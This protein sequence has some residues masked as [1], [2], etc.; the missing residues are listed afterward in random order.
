MMPSTRARLVSTHRDTR[1]AGEM[2]RRRDRR[3]TSREISTA[4][5]CL[6]IFGSSRGALGDVVG[7]PLSSTSFPHMSS[8]RGGSKRWTYPPLSDCTCDD[9]S[10]GGGRG[11]QSAR[12]APAQWRGSGRTCR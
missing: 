10:D 4:S 12:V 2:D 9:K 11:C 5:S 8:A 7:A 3:M 1:A 6:T